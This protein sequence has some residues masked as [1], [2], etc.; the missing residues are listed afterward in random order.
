MARKVLES[1][2]SEAKRRWPVEAVSAVHRIGW[3][4]VGE[5]AVVIAVSSRHRNDAF[6]ACRYVIDTLKRDA[7]IWKIEGGSRATCC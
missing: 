6:E 3:I 1:I 2:A 5:E 7:P 4:P